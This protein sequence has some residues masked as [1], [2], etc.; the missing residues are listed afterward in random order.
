[1]P[2]L[3]SVI[4]PHLNQAEYLQRC[5]ESLARQTYAGNVEIVVVDNGSRALPRDIIA[6]FPN[7]RLEQEE[8]PGPGPARNHGVARSSGEILA[9]TDADC[10]VD[11]NWLTEIAARL[12][13]S[14]AKRIL[15]G[16][17][18][19]AVADPKRLTQIEAYESVFQYRQEEYIRKF[20]FSGTGN[21]AVRREDFDVVGPFAG[22][23][24]SEDRD[25]GRRA[26]ALGHVIEYVPEI[27]V[28]HPARTAFSEVYEKWARHIDHDFSEYR[29]SPFGRM[30]W[31]LY[32]GG[33]AASPIAEMRRIFRS[34]RIS[35]LRSR[36]LA[37]TALM[38]IRL[39]RAKRMISLLSSTSPS[40]Q[41][42]NRN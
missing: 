35:T 34:T 9:F 29:N 30:R 2:A 40:S 13:D 5:L 3:I 15:G 19:I 14:K 12:Q 24:I 1:L 38:R 27:I 16:D 17:V 31:I 42:W 32:A 37:M 22:I 11:E 10:T 39:Y 20:R 26:I 4:I 7:A 28:Y 33:V 6:G 23:G 25:W 8:I 21:L 18:R 36:R 41:A